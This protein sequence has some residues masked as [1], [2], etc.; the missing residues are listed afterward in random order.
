[1]AR[2]NEILSIEIIGIEGVSDWLLLSSKALYGATKHGIWKAAKEIE[3]TTL[4]NI[5]S[6]PFKSDL[7]KYGVKH[8]FDSTALSG[9]VDILG[10]DIYYD[11]YRLRFFE[12]GTKLRKSKHGKN[13]GQIRPNYFFKNAIN[14]NS[15]RVYS[16]V[17]DTIYEKISVLNNG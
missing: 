6:S 11:S 8:Y 2:R 10:S 16:I 5:S 14:A 9:T 1:M 4:A 3:Q 13:Y 12:G 15:A 7:L 17:K